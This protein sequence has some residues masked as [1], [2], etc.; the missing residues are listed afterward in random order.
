MNIFSLVTPY[1]SSNVLAKH[2]HEKVQTLEEVP[3]FNEDKR[4]HNRKKQDQALWAVNNDIGSVHECKLQHT[5][6]DNFGQKEK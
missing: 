1:H 3:I 5:A 4:K 6:S 2:G